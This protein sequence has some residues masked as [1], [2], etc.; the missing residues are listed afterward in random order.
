MADRMLEQI[1]L[2]RKGYRKHVNSGYA[3]T[4]LGN[5]LTR[6]VT[7]LFDTLGPGYMVI[8]YMVVSG[9]MVNF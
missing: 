3:E 1:W 7:P 2:T 4:N 6:A 5:I 8:G 9:Y